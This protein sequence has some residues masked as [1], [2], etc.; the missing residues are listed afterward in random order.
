MWYYLSSCVVYYRC[1]WYD[2]FD[3]NEDEKSSLSVRTNHIRNWWL[4]FS[5][6]ICFEWQSLI[7][8]S[9]KEKSWKWFH[10]WIICEA[11]GGGFFL[12]FLSQT[13]RPWRQETRPFLH[14]RGLAGVTFSS[15]KWGG[16]LT[17]HTAVVR[18]L[19][20]GTCYPSS[21]LVECIALLATW[22]KATCGCLLMRTPK[23]TQHDKIHIMGM[24]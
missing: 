17:L 23:M 16:L 3:D 8:W 24:L 2:D 1:F 18:T 15:H 19:T 4:C 14:M 9:Q 20:A 10:L 21:G 6:L 12:P 5:I 22:Y 13:E 7:G 11:A